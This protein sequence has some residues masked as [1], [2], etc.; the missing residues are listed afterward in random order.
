MVKCYPPKLTYW[1]HKSYSTFYQLK[2][3]PQLEICRSPEKQ[4]GPLNKHPRI[5]GFAINWGL[6]RSG[7]RFWFVSI[8]LNGTALHSTHCD[9]CGTVRVA[10]RFTASGSLV[11]YHFFSGYYIWVTILL[12]LSSW[13]FEAWRWMKLKFLFF[14]FV[15]LIWSKES[16]FNEIS[17]GFEDFFLEK[18][19]KTTEKEDTQRSRGGSSEF[20]IFQKHTNIT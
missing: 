9:R 19:D 3:K 20:R 12:I 7:A 6:P 8:R 17:E 1:H 18:M 13:E 4:G 10:A 2:S 14:C 5:S 16:E 11:G 15:V